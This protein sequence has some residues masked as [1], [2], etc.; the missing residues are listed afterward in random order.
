MYSFTPHGSTGWA[1][2]ASPRERL[3]AGGPRVRRGRAVGR[4]PRR[5]VPVLRSGH[6]DRV[7]DCL[8]AAAVASPECDRRR[9]RDEGDRRQPDAR[10][11]MVRRH[12]RPASAARRTRLARGRRSR[13]QHPVGV[14]ELAQVHEQERALL[15]ADSVRR[16]SARARPARAPRGSSAR[17]AEAPRRQPR[18]VRLA[19][20]LG[21]VGVRLRSESRLRAWKGRDRGCRRLFWRDVGGHRPLRGLALRVELGLRLGRRRVRPCR[22]PSA[23]G[24]PETSSGRRSAARGTREAERRLHGARRDPRAAA[25]PAVRPLVLLFS[26]L[27]SL[28]RRRDGRRR[29]GRGRGCLVFGLRSRGAGSIDPARVI[30]VGG[31]SAAVVRVGIAGELRSFLRRGDRGERNRRPGDTRST[32]FDRLARLLDDRLRHAADASSP[33]PAAASSCS[34]PCCARVMIADAWARAHSSVCSTSARAAFVS[35]V[36]WWRDCSSSRVPRASASRSSWVASRFASASSSRASLRAAFS[37]SARWRS[38]SWR[39][40]STS[41]SRSCISLLAAAH[42]VLGA[43]R[44]ARRRPAARRARARRRTRRPRG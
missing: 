21:G 5:V 30:A 43:A 23:L 12:A 17:D 15:V 24:E 36:A 2:P 31:R 11:S 13:R 41:A 27:R 10:C 22:P 37:I 32:R 18:R 1:T 40:R 14:G 34:A 9:R 4:G 8:A 16:R 29:P 38:L 6:R 44:A 20:R 28:R 25:G 7:R 39:K 19:G 35:S 33:S 3:P 26:R 42:L